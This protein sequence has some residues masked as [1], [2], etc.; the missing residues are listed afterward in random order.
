MTETRSVVSLHLPHDLVDIVFLYFQS[1]K[2]KW[3]HMARAGE[4]EMCLKCP[5]A[6]D[7]ELHWE[8]G[9]RGALQGGHIEIAKQMI[10]KA[11]HTVDYALYYTCNAGN[12]QMVQY[13]I[14]R[15]ASDWVMGLG[16]AR[17][18]GHIEIEDFMYA[19]VQ[20]KLHYSF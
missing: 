1:I 5:N 19:M 6:R 20:N 8:M 10:D 4:Y 15:G 3:K 9:L 17:L 7:E 11:E 12:M 14:D 13:A 16:A 18:G 2:R